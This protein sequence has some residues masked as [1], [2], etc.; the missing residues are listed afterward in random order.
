MTAC[1][2]SR[3]FARKNRKPSNPRLGAEDRRLSR[4]ALLKAT[5]AAGVGGAALLASCGDDDDGDTGDETGDDTGDE[6][7][8]DTGGETGGD[9]GGETGGDTG[10]ETGDETGGATGDDTGD[11][12][13]AKKRVAIIGGGIAGA[14]LAWL[15]DEACECELFEARD[16][17]GG[18]LRTVDYEVGGE[19]YALDLGAEYFHP[20]PHP[21]YT[22]LLEQLGVLNPAATESDGVFELESSITLSA[23]GETNPRFVSPIP[24]KRDWPTSASWNTSGVKAFALMSSK[25]R[26]LELDD[27][28][29]SVTLESWLK[30]SGI[31]EATRE[32]IVIPWVASLFT[33]NIEEAHE[34]SARS[35]MVYMSR[36]LTSD[37]Q[38]LVNY[39]TI[40][41]GMRSVAVQMLDACEN[42][43]QHVSAAVESVTRE[44][45]GKFRVRAKGGLDATFDHVV[46]AASGEATAKLL[47]ELP[48]VDA[49]QKAAAGVA[50][51][52]ATL[53][54]HLDPIYADPDPMNW[55][56]LNCMTNGTNCEASMQLAISKPKAADGTAVPIWKSWAHHRAESPKQEIARTEFRHVIP[57]VPT[58]KAT[59]A[60]KANNGAGG[61]WL[62]GGWTTEYDS[63]ETAL[64]S[65]MRVARGLGF[66]TPRFKS[67]PDTAL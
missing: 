58:L 47:K 57:S 65:A 52:D 16:V 41:K 3:R 37:T 42:L 8:G 31:D 17:M 15:L 18:N 60:I 22:K 44:A 30:R 39:Y 46:F 33:S 21:T 35:A 32:S 20:G 12:P 40:N 34:Y 59:E 48:E 53:L 29:Y 54:F 4:R 64:V 67:L 9:T 55:S 11:D 23:P 26:A 27:A 36:S 24:G 66:E 50:H 7:G 51:H 38:T 14:S 61:V 6:T 2:S 25:V 5:L 62:A 45:N 49:L 56:F 28:S 43:T 19:M 13:N 10:D 63:Q 1:F